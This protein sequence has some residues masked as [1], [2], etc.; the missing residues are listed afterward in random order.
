MEELRKNIK[1]E[2][3]SMSNNE[4]ILKSKQIKERILTFSLFNQSNSIMFY[5]QK[6]NEVNLNGLMSSQLNHQKRKIILPKTNK[7][8]FSMKSYQINNLSED[9]EN[10]AFGIMEPKKDCLE[11]NTEQIDLVF[12]PGVAFDL[13]GNRLGHGLGYY[14]RFLEDF[15]GIKVG[16]AYDFQ[17]VDSIKVKSHDVPM[18]YV[19]TE[20]RVIKTNREQNKMGQLLSGKELSEK[21]LTA[22]K[23]KVEILENK[24]TLAIVSVGEDLASKIYIKKKL[25]IAEKIGVKARHYKLN[26]ETKEEELLGLI[27]KLNKDDNVDGF[28]VQLPLPKQINENK[29]INSINPRKDVDGFHPINMGKIFLEIFEEETDMIPA[30]PYGI[31]KIIEYYNLDLEGKKVVIVGKSNIVGKPIAQLMLMKNATVTIAHKK[32]NNLAEHTKDADIIVVAVGKEKLITADM[33]KEG[34]IVIDV[35]MNRTEEGKI[36]GDVDF[37]NVKEKASLITPVPGGVGP[38]T[39][40]MLLYNL[41]KTKITMRKVS[42]EE[43]KSL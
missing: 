27:E 36:V 37:E 12:V 43:D 41:V 40:T 1:L 25:K 16:V 23:E 21:I 32:T 24:P 14:D 5:Y 4:V 26:E 30:T 13:A 28:I 8:D 22:L 35:G 38:M 17:I 19:I 29:V 15:N 2:R 42:N 20:K 6:G 34:V 3:D 33:V 11:I 9:L 39:V 18:D 10:G 31:M 7:D